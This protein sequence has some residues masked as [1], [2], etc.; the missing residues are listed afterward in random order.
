[1]TSPTQASVL[2]QR[3]PLPRHDHARDHVLLRELRKPRRRMQSAAALEASGE[4]AARRIRELAWDLGSDLEYS[5][6][7]AHVSRELDVPYDTMRAIIH[8]QR[9]TV[10]TAT[11]D[12]VARKLG[13]PAGAFYD[14]RYG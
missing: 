5:R 12:R 2:L 10:S 8:N 4:V 6:W 13:L 7:M 9:P 14:P 11:V 1:M 3:A